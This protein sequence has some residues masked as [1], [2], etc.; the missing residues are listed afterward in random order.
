MTVPKAWPPC[1]QCG[2]ESAW[3]FT[4]NFRKRFYLCVE[5]ADPNGQ[6]MRESCGTLSLLQDKRLAKQQREHMARR[7]AEKELGAGC[8]YAGEAEWLPFEDEVLEPADAQA[9][10]DALAED[11]GLHSVRVECTTRMTVRLYGRYYGPRTW[12]AKPPRIVLHARGR[13]LYVLLHEFA[14]HVRREE[15][16][17]DHSW[18]RGPEPMH[19]EA[20]MSA[21]QTTVQAWAGQPNGEGK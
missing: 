2:K 9:A 18:Q 15:R 5:C 4:N 13:R 6:L 11:M 20:F 3:R 10:C 7:V 21:L 16:R 1:W 12:P 8:F 17:R 19:G 14:H